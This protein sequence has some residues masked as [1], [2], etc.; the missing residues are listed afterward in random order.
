MNMEN[1]DRLCK[2]ETLYMNIKTG[3][4]DVSDGWDDFEYNYMCGLLR[5]VEKDADGDFVEVK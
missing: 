1:I 4:V 5:M 2:A 3:S